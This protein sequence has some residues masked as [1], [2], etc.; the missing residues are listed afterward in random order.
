[1]LGDKAGKRVNKYVSD[2]VVFDL[3]TTGISV[4]K[5][6]VVE[7]SAVK[8]HG[9]KPTE[10]FT[11]LVNPGMHIPHE[12]SRV[13]HITDDMVKD[14]PE[15]CGVLKEFDCFIGD[16]VLVGHNIHTFDLKFLYRDAQKFY[17]KVLSNDYIDTLKLS[18]DCLPQLPH[19]RLE[20]LAKYYHIPAEGAHRALND[21]RVNQRVFESLGKELDRR[22]AG[23]SGCRVCARC[24]S[25]MKKR[26]GKFGEF[27]G[28]SAFPDCRYTEP[29]I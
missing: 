4:T 12:A 8:V 15:F 7:I 1:M 21:C 17:G 22:N 24:G 20:D 5:D 25:P 29:C 18:R 10:E 11:S 3:E 9:G 13:N 16:M 27:W 26:N 6:R 19:Y 28:C 2:Y 23:A 14:A